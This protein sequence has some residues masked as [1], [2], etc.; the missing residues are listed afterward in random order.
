M[1]NRHRTGELWLDKK[2]VYLIDA[3]E[4]DVDCLLEVYGVALGAKR[5]AFDIERRKKNNYSKKTLLGQLARL[6][7]DKENRGEDT[8]DIEVTK[9]P[10]FYTYAEWGTDTFTGKQGM[11]FWD[12]EPSTVSLKEHKVIEGN[13]TGVFILLSSVNWG[14][15]Y[16]KNSEILNEFKDDEPW[17]RTS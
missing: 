14:D 3:T 11:G 9:P 8:E 16:Y 15:Y 1:L 7:L 13:R 17:K 12:M 2:L 6:L 10:L 4:S 5:K